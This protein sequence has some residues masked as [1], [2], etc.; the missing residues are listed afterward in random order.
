M[1]ITGVLFVSV[2]GAMALPI[3]F[4]GN[5]GIPDNYAIIKD[6]PNEAAFG[7]DSFDIDAVLFDMDSNF[8]YIG[9]DT[10]GAFDR[11]G[12]ATAFPPVTQFL[13]Q[14]DD[15]SASYFFTL[16]INDTS[17]TMFQGVSPIPLPV[18]IWDAMIDND[19]EI[20]FDSTMMPGFNWDDFAFQ[21][22]L[23]NSDTAADDVISARVTDIPE[24][25]TMSLQ[26]LG[27]IAL[28]RRRRKA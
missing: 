4:D 22:R 23:D 15:G 5:I 12:G 3:N 13:F 24:P 16:L 28:L 10:I 19:L 25:A 27:A 11:N 1:I 9:V 26:G 2:S 20:R 18:T 8:L 17:T 14:L 21:A 7:A 6:D